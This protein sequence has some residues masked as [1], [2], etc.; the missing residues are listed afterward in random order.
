MR[1]SSQTEWCNE[2]EGRA[3]PLSETATRVDDAGKLMPDDIIADMG[4]VLPSL[5]TGL[6]VS[7]VYVSPQ[8]VSVAISCNTGG[9]LTGSYARDSLIPYAAYPLTPLVDSV[10]GWIVFGN[11]RAPARTQYL[12]AT[13]A[14]AGIETRA[15]RLIQPPGVTRFVRKGGNQLVQAQG[16]VRLEGDGSFEILQDPANAQNVIVRLKADSQARFTEACSQ[17]ASADL[18]GVPPIRRIA[19]VPA[20]ANGQIT[21]RFE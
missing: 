10:S 16:L 14:Q 1:T 5:Y 21:I 17:E 9:L 11:H 12:F 6:R 18:C 4:L 7:S 19:N 20:N 15:T 2:N 3:Y 8:L 13:A